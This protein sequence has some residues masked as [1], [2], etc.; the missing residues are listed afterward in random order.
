MASKTRV[1]GAACTSG[2]TGGGAAPRWMVVVAF[3]VVVLLAVT[4][5]VRL[6]RPGRPRGGG[7]QPFGEPFEEGPRARLVY[8]YMDGCGWCLRFDPEW[9]K[10]ARERRADMKRAGVQAERVESQSAEAAAL[11]R[12]LVTGYPTV[13]LLP[14]GG[15]PPVV[16]QGE[17][18]PAG[19]AAFLSSHGLP[20]DPAK[21]EGFTYKRI[22]STPGYVKESNQS[23][24]SGGVSPSVAQSAQKGAGAVNGAKKVGS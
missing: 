11:P 17:R 18:T 7:A 9:Q 3:L 23:T 6:L 24:A 2:V 10:F 21:R 22:D 13:L 5:M 1:R 16:F 19:L 20:L 15:K 8:V 12:G 4:L 14:A